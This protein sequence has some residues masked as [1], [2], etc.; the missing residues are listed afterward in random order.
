MDNC[1]LPKK[2]AETKV[3][4]TNHHYLADAIK[5]AGDVHPNPGPNRTV[6]PKFQKKNKYQHKCQNPTHL[7][8]LLVILVL[9]VNK[10]H[11]FHKSNLS[12]IHTNI[13]AATSTVRNIGFNRSAK[14]IK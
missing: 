3:I 5:L 10:I 12:D 9:T 14:P 11:E 7:V 4:K 6:Y 8:L 1:H 13:V 2:L